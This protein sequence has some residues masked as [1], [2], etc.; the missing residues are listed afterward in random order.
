MRPIKIYKIIAKL[1]TK[2]VKR[3]YYFK[4]FAVREILKIDDNVI[5]RRLICVEL[6]YINKLGNK[7]NNNFNV[8]SKECLVLNSRLF[9]NV[10]YVFFYYFP[11]FNSHF[12]L[13]C[14]YNIKREKKTTRHFRCWDLCLSPWALHWMCLSVNE[15]CLLFYSNERM[16]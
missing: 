9:K 15:W 10:S 16:G 12:A 13:R 14:L 2:L 7:I 8:F 1:R 3:S 4:I 6:N 5:N 11:F